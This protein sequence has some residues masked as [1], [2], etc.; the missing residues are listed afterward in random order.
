MSTR[1][2]KHTI[3][4]KFI[5]RVLRQ[6]RPN[7]LIA[8]CALIAIVGIASCSSSGE[9]ITRHENFIRYSSERVNVGKAREIILRNST[10][11]DP[12]N[13]INRY[14][15]KF[16]DIDGARYDEE[17]D[18]LVI[19]GPEA[20]QNHSKRLPPLLL[21][22]FAIA[23]DI[24][25]AGK[26]LGVSIGTISGRVPTQSDIEHMMRTR[27]LPIEYIP[28]STFGTHV[29]SVLY[30]IDRC[31]KGLAHGEDNLTQKSVMCSVQG[32]IPVSRRLQH[33]DTWEADKPRPLGLWWFVPDEPGIAFEGYTIKFV[34]YRMRVEYKSLVDDPA[35]AAFGKH[36]NEHFDEYAKEFPTFRELVRLHKLVQVARWYKESGFPIE[37]FMQGYKRLKIKTPKTTRMIR[38]LVDSKRIPGPYPGSYYVHELFLIG[39]VDLSPRNYYIPVTRLPKADVSVGRVSSW[40]PRERYR[41]QIRSSAPRYGSF[42]QHRAMVPSFVTPILNSRPSPMSYGWTASVN[43]RC[44]T[45]VSIPMKIGSQS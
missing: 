4:I 30:E 12:W 36:L 8:L 7:C 24:F 28:E 18:R 38:T 2:T 14:L 3:S 35:V 23:L 27:E 16:D 15:G 25:E 45:V 17:N 26:D 19:W 9:T 20:D 31:L 22:D 43:G 41:T 42:R 11:G 37:D 1:Q 6:W 34:R 33:D 40:R 10:V 21:D 5:W 44:Y 13:E 39:G 29:G 32:Y